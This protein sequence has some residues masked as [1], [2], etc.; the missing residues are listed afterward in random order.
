MVIMDDIEA[1]GFMFNYGKVLGS[2]QLS[3]TDHQN[4][5]EGKEISIDRT[6]RLLY[7]T[8]SRAKQSLAL[9]MY[10]DN[11]QKVRDHMIS[12]GWFTKDEIDIG[13]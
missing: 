1:R 13:T 6:T 7:V 5:S 10:S 2:K 9:V 4:I 3:T 8:C 12:K 11:P